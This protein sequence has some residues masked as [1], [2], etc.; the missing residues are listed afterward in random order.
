VQGTGWKKSAE[1]RITVREKWWIYGHRRHIPPT[2]LYACARR[3]ARR[4]DKQ[5]LRATYTRCLEPL[6]YTNSMYSLGGI[7]ASIRSLLIY[8]GEE[9]ESSISSSRREILFG[10]EDDKG[11]TKRVQSYREYPFCD[12]RS[13]RLQTQ[14]AKKGHHGFS[15]RPDVTDHS[16]FHAQNLQLLIPRT[17]LAKK[18]EE[19]YAT[20]S[21]CGF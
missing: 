6:Q 2:R 14:Y 16:L 21:P 4:A 18:E 9:R 11:G 7:F 17:R 20:S 8:K 1:P 12:A 19:K 15:S 13:N 5:I 3:R 10:L